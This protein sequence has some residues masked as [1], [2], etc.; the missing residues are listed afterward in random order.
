M[1][2]GKGLEYFWLKVNEQSS[3]RF[4]L[5]MRLHRQFGESKGIDAVFDARWI[6]RGRSCT[7]R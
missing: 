6:E 5:L 2:E 7:W 3:A 4:M 1:L